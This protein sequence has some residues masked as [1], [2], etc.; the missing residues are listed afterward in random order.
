MYQ[1][2]AHQHMQL[3][4]DEFSPFQ[5]DIWGVCSCGRGREGWGWRRGG[6]CPDGPWP[7]LAGCQLP[8][9]L[10]CGRR[11]RAGLGPGHGVKSPTLR[12]EPPG[13]GSLSAR[14]H[15]LSLSTW[16]L[17]AQHRGWHSPDPALRRASSPGPESTS[18]PQLPPGQLISPP[19]PCPDGPWTGELA[20][21]P[22][23]L[24]P[25]LALPQ[26]FLSFFKAFQFSL[27]TYL[28]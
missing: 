19:C 15:T 12:M 25:T 17:V 7:W 26:G 21:R 6:G 3:E 14:L 10:V 2:S 20:H 5:W 22:G 4:C 8:G 11:A 9:A 1:G 27:C 24:P 16:E 23:M 18:G 28:R 13:V